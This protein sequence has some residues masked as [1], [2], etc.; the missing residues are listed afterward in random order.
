MR[1]VL[2]LRNMAS[3]VSAREAPHRDI[4]DNPYKSPPCSLT[5]QSPPPYDFGNLRAAVLLPESM[6]SSCKQEFICC[7]FKRM[8]EF[9]IAVHL[10]QKVIS[11]HF[12]S[13]MLCALLL[14]ALVLWAMET[15]MRLRPLYSSGEPL[16]LR[17][18]TGFSTTTCG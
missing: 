12:H 16:Q 5:S 11:T 3:V 4:V 18:P 9:P 17:Y 6:V 7:P 1:G 2:N 10:T 8:L 15:G 14:P 13:Q